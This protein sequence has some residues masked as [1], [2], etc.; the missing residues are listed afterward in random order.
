MLPISC[1]T[2]S[3][4]ADRQLMQAQ[5]V[6]SQIT[7]GKISWDDAVVKYSCA[8]ESK[9]NSGDIGWIRYAEPMPE[10]FNDAAFKL[11]PGQISQG[12]RTQFGV[13][14]IKC[15]EIKPGKMGPRDAEDQVRQHATR[16]L[17]DRI[18]QQHRSELTIAYTDQWPNLQ[19]LRAVPNK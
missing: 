18:A 6:R 14:L 12:V 17:F 7:E 1:L 3:E 15:N 9:K 5:D 16:A 4:A 19:Q 10:V 11:D 13:H 8:T 2:T